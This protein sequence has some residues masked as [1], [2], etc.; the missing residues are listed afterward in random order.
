MLHREKTEVVSTAHA[1]PSVLGAAHPARLH[2]PEPAHMLHEQLRHVVVA[3]VQRKMQ[4]R[5]ARYAC[6]QS[7][8]VCQ[9]ILWKSYCCQECEL[10][11][12]AFASCC[13]SSSTTS[14]LALYAAK[15][16]GAQPF[17]L[18]ASLTLAP[19]FF[20]KSRNT[21]RCPS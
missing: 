2:S 16:K 10:T 1:A 5:H 7:H 21:S 8:T 14:A 18:V 13:S 9:D 11:W 19:S 15:C 6:L 4:R 17:S 3:A 12:P 20:N